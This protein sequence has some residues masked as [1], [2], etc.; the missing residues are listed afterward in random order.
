M[1][2]FQVFSTGPHWIQG[3]MALTAPKMV[4]VMMINQ[5][6]CLA[7]PVVSLSRVTAKAVLVHA[8]AVIVTVARLLRMRRNLA[9]LESSR[10]RLCRPSLNSLTRTVVRMFVAMMANCSG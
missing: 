9:M 8:I 7:A 1:A 10:L 2:G 3:T 5:T 6:K 4:S